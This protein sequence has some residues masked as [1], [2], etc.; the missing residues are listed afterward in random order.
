MK[1]ARTTIG[2]AL[3]AA[4]L[5][6]HH[7][8]LPADPGVGW[9]PYLW[10]IWIGFFFIPWAAQATSTTTMV[11]TVVAIA[12]FL[13]LY[14]RYW[15][16]RSTEGPWIIALIAALG[17]ALIPFNSAGGALLIYAGS[18]AG[19]SFRPR[20]TLVVLAALAAVAVGEY[21]ALGLPLIVWIWAPTI[22]LMAGLA[23]MWGAER[24]RQHCAL[25]R[26]QD[27]VKRLATAAERERIGRD[28]HDL[29]GHTLTLISVKAELAARLAE[30]DL[31]GATKEIR[32]LEAIAR[33]AL[34]QVREAV[35]G[36]RAGGIAGE[37][38]SARAA[39]RSADVVFEVDAVAGAATLAEEG[40]L[41]MIVREAVTNIVRHA[42]AH[43]C[44]L[45]VRREE[46][47]LVLE[48][49]DDGRGGVRTEGNGIL[50]MRERLRELGGS[51][52]IDSGRQGTRL[53]A[54]IPAD[55]TEAAPSALRERLA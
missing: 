52:K 19:Y 41:A 34:A 37:I 39:L 21:V 45:C 20:F 38:V 6:L 22:I 30:R 4:V 25:Q 8:L 46:A 28:L 9:V 3:C 31:P 40:V 1:Q 5:W 51:L 32:E 24:H 33:D 35:G 54:R 7:R 18:F 49:S 10:L 55:A 43:H 50:G 42:Q 11:A 44:V 26:S 13:P 15:W 17:C 29:L 48:I 36:Y 27:E 2:T 14:F 16:V 53:R 23:N 12:L 47:A